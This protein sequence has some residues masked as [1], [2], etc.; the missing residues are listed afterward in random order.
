MILTKTILLCPFHVV[1]DWRCC[2]WCWCL[3]QLHCALCDVGL[4]CIVQTVNWTYLFLCTHVFV[5]QCHNIGGVGVFPVAL[6]IVWR[7]SSL[8][9]ANRL[10]PSA[11]G[12]R[13][14]AQTA[15]TFLPISPSLNN[16][17]PVL[18]AIFHVS[19]QASVLD[20]IQIIAHTFVFQEPQLCLRDGVKKKWYFLGIFPKK[21]WTPHPH[22]LATFRNPNDTFG[23]KKVELSR[24][25]P[26]ATKISHKFQESRPAPLFRKFS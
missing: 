13:P 7:W 16:L 17:V 1:F 3:S 10:D 26:I 11:A 23:Q 12:S 5:Q 25:K 6:C 18:G 4:H 15:R 8:H 2:C 14:T 24:P 21:R 9:C 22:L 20:L 19:P